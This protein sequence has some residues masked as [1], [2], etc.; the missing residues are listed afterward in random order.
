MRGMLIEIDSTL[1]QI[2]E[3][4]DKVFFGLIKVS[5]ETAQKFSEAE[6]T[7]KQIILNEIHREK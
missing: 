1:V 5:G 3:L 6:D 7:A 4:T 2:I